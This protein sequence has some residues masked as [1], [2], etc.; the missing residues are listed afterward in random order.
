ML[1]IPS[2]RGLP[3][4]PANSWFMIALKC[5]PVCYYWNPQLFPT[6]I[7][8]Y[9][10]NN[11]LVIIINK[12][13][14][15]S[16]SFLRNATKCAIFSSKRRKS[17]SLIQPYFSQLRSQSSIEIKLQIIFSRITLLNYLIFPTSS[18]SL[19]SSSLIILYI[20]MLKYTSL[21]SVLPTKIT[22]RNILFIK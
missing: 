6:M 4:N 8:K 20:H 9:P 16:F 1:F 11:Y 22:M 14:T 10:I 2:L 17:N 13:N 5:C 19:L 21:H 15:S 7:I 12:V 3:T 18:F